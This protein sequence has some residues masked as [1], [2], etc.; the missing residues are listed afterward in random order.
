MNGESDDVSISDPVEILPTMSGTR[1]LFSMNGKWGSYNGSTTNDADDEE[2]SGEDDEADT[3]AETQTDT[4]RTNAFPKVIFLG[5]GSSFPGVTKTVT[6][7]LV[8]TA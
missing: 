4:T 1:Y 3:M 8:H 6:S 2:S 5:T 7:I